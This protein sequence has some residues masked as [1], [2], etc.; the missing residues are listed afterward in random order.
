MRHQLA[1]NIRLRE[2]ATFAAYH[3]DTNQ[4]AVHAIS[5][6][7]EARDPPRQAYVWGG[8]ATGKS[9][10]LQAVCHRASLQRRSSVYLPLA[11]FDAAQADVLD[12]LFDIEAVCIDDIDVTVGH[13][14]WEHA[15]F[16]AI[17]TTLNA[18]HCLVLASRDNPAH[19]TPDLR[20]LRSRLLWGPVFH[21]KPLD[22]AGKLDALKAR[23]KECGL[24]LKDDAGRFL[25]NNCRRDLP[26]LF[27]AL[28]RLD[29][30]SLAAQRRVTIPFI[31]SVLHL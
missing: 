26:S 18:G 27:A 6:L 16:N 4:D 13:A 30:A 29:R 9:H 11:Q 31:K 23:A 21:L 24:E 17:N 7:A 5:A 14:A 2:G 15:L 22:D 28:A 19:L 8:P 1:L 20:D 12:D 3:A 10:L 25:L